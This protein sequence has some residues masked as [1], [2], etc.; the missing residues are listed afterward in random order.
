MFAVFFWTFM[1]GLA[2]AFIGIPILIAVVVYLGE[3]PATQWIATLLSS[4]GWRR[5]AADSPD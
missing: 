4:A 5:D 1:W 3:V 2:G